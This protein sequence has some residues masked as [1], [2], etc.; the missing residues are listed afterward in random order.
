MA[1]NVSEEWKV[2]QQATIRR[3]GFV[4]VELGDDDTR[5]NITVNPEFIS[6]GKQTNDY[7]F[8]SNVPLE[9]V[10][11]YAL[12]VG[13]ILTKV[14]QYK[15]IYLSLDSDAITRNVKYE[16]AC[17]YT[18]DFSDEPVIVKI[19]DNRTELPIPIPSGCTAMFISFKQWCCDGEQ[20]K[21]KAVYGGNNIVIPAD[22]IK[23]T[24]HYRSYD[25]MGLELPQNNIMIEVFNFDD[26]YTPL[27]ESYTNERIKIKVEYGYVLSDTT[28]IIPG[29]I[30]Y[31]SNIENDEG[32]FTLTGDNSLTLID[33]DGDFPVNIVYGTIFERDPGITPVTYKD[34]VNDMPMIK[35]SDIL[36]DISTAWNINIKSNESFD[37]MMSIYNSISGK[38]IEIFQKMV[39]S[40]LQRCYI[41]RNDNIQV[42]NVY[43]NTPTSYINLLN[44][45]QKPVI[46]FSKKIRYVAIDG[47]NFDSCKRNTYTWTPKQS[48]MFYF[49]NIDPTK[50][51][52]YEMS[53]VNNITLIEKSN[54][55]TDDGA[56]MSYYG[57]LSR[58]NSN[59]VTLVTVDLSTGFQTINYPVDNTGEICDIT[60]DIAAPASPEKIASYFSNRRL[61]E[62]N[63]RGD[64][65]RDVGDYVWVSQ[66]DDNDTA[67][68]EKGL[69]LESELIFD[70]SF[71]ENAVVRIIEHEFEMEE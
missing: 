29:G 49:Y 2:N 56:V 44:S 13:F 5:H 14:E 68:Y 38:R 33:D 65:A 26:F 16:I 4:Q 8:V 22:K 11:E 52:L 60:N 67:T 18:S 3:R 6:E 64:P 41:D 39:N 9:N 58:T 54:Q 69:V 17:Y 34:V 31:T 62:I 36:T 55:K 71:K 61:M 25:P 48:N 21:V 40:A 32:I 24:R 28:E 57:T 47:F 53:T 70:G 45:L 7:A 19:S 50:E 63:L 59:T 43:S 66:T 12:P 23:T 51:C 20:V 42:I 30:F 35:Y 46:T 10:S 1:V 15:A 37:N 27:Y